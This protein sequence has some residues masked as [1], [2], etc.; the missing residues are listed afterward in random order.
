MLFDGSTI[1]MRRLM[2]LTHSH[3]EF[4]RSQNALALEQLAWVAQGAMGPH[5]FTAAMDLAR[6]EV[7][8]PDYL[9]MSLAF[10][11][12]Q[13]AAQGDPIFAAMREDRGVPEAIELMNAVGNFLV[14]DETGGID[15]MA[16]HG[17]AGLP[18]LLDIGLFHSGLL[19]VDAHAILGHSIEPR[20]SP[21]TV[22]YLHALYQG[23]ASTDVVVRCATMV[24]FELHA[25]V[26]IDSLWAA[27]SAATGRPP[28][29][30]AYFERHVGGEDPAEAYHVEMTQRLIDRVIAPGERDRF[31]S[32]VHGAYRLHVEWCRALVERPLE[33]AGEEPRR[34]LW[35]TGRCH[36]GGV[37]FEV[38]APAVLDVVRCNCSICSM[39]G[40]L[41]LLVPAE[42]VRLLAGSELLTTYQFGRGIARHTF[43]R[44]CGIKPFYRP[45]SN[46]SGFSVDVRCLDRST[47]ARVDVRDFDGRHWEESIRALEGLP[48]APCEREHAPAPGLA[49]G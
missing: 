10:R 40:F 42:R 36:C 45:R 5:P 3:H 14:W 4:E 8:L 18:R 17:K 26:M 30:L 41:H 9:G 1:F 31:R 44:I 46:P 20:F 29:G 38:E 37:R 34:A 21:P 47:I 11:Y 49:S 35:H 39:S 12:L 6:L 22:R 27:I 7:V 25:S 33:A 2:E 43:C 23:L 32:E 19:R 15:L 13:A 48:D 24:A 28:E 16:G